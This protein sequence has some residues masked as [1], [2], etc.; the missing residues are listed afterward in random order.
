MNK[1]ETI[2]IKRFIELSRLADKRYTQNFTSFLN[3]NEQS[4]FYANRKEYM[5][6]PYS[7]YGGYQDAERKMVCFHGGMIP[8]NAT[9]LSGS[10]IEIDTK[11]LAKLYPI[12][13]VHISPLHAKFSDDLNHRDFL[14]AILNL[15]IDRS[16]VGDIFLKE[17]EGYVFCDT[18]IANFIVDSLTK[19]KHTNV[20]C[21]L[22]SEEFT[23]TPSFITIHGTITSVRLDAI[24]A[25]AFQCSRS[26]IVGLISGGKV[27]VNG[28]EITSSSYVLKEGDIVSVRGKGKF[29]YEGTTYVTKKGRYSITVKRYN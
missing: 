3:L 29:I 26:G 7:I 12:S 23:I 1:E 9:F 28:K 8:E 13:C 11:D 6:T 4:L 10:E 18:N 19:I 24:I 15:G 16:R 27:F 22:T 25:T 2:L 17:N 5:D 21:D 14:G 20:T